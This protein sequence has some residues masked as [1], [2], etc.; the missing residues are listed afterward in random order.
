MKCVS[1]GKNRIV[2]K[3]T[4]FHQLVFKKCKYN[5]VYLYSDMGVRSTF[6]KI[7]MNTGL[8]KPALANSTHNVVIT[9]QRKQQQQL[10]S[11]F[12]F[13]TQATING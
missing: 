10:T 1:V 4:A 9:V 5:P 11:G 13:K 2:E 8:W 7:N 6:I 3:K 12:E